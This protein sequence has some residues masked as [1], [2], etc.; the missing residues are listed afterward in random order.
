MRN[1]LLLALLLALPL[2]AQTDQ[3]QFA[4]IVSR[5][6]VRSPTWEP[7]R[8]NQYSSAPWPD[9]G[10]A[11]G[12]LTPHG[13]T[14]MK[15]MG[16]FYRDHFSALLAQRPCAAAAYFRADSEQRTL[17]SARALAEGLLP[18]CQTEIHTADN[19]PIFQGTTPDPKLAAAA[20]AGRTG[21]QPDALIAAHQ[22]AF[23]QLNRLLKGSG[24][25]VKSLAVASTLSEDLLLEYA[26]GMTGDKL[27]W[28]RLT[29]ASLLEVMSLHTAYADLMRRTPYLARTRGSS[30]LS[31][32]LKSLEQAAAGKAPA[33]LL[34]IAGHDTN[35]SSLS[36]MLGLSW[37]LPSYQPDDA[38]P[39]GALIFTLWRSAEGQY[40][41]RLQ[42]IA[43]TLDQMHGTVP[44]SPQNPPAIANV[45]VPACSSAQ[46]GYPCPLNAFPH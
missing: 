36:G 45:F 9:F 15:I 1:K 13:R 38:P 43:Q 27:G 18:D 4:V 33:S 32:I 7:Q 41:V 2:A 24:Q 23:D 17:E 11:P 25:T 12:L 35:L 44:L 46:E 26:E 20:V 34:V 19:D 10:V 39:G 16:T 8:L 42:F 6:G 31:Y 40:S 21:P 5:H 30:L 37:L 14:L 28:G 22:P 29:P 3:L